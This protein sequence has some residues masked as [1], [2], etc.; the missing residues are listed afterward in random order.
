M[1][2]DHEVK[3]ANVREVLATRPGQDLIWDILEMTGLYVDNSFNAHAGTE[4]RRAVGIEL[5]QLIE[6]ADPK[7][8]GN[9]LITKQEQEDARDN[10]NDRDNDGNDSSGSY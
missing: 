5:L 3:L 8:Y 10:R 2:K 9:L 1:D 4:G 7:A 6:D